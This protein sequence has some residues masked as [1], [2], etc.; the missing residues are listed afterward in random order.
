MAAKKEDTS[1]YPALGRLLTW[2]DRPG[3]PLKLVWILAAACL[4]V[5]LAD[6][7][8]EKHE[9][10]SVPNL[11]FFYGMFGFVMF[12]ALILAAKALRTLIRRPEDFYAPKAIDT[13]DYPE[14]ELE[15][16]SNDD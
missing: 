10:F 8:Y 12:T 1:N 15:L 3:N 2:V 5:A 4:I 7:T 13:E 6:F 16:R 9:Y 11:P 14:Q